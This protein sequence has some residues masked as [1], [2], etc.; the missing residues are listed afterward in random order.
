MNKVIGET[1]GAFTKGQPESTLGNWFA[2]IIYEQSCK[3]YGKPIDFATQN[4]GGLRIPSLPKGELTKGKIYE[5]MPFDNMV[6]ILE[7][8]AATVVQL[9]ERIAAQGGWPTSKQLRFEIKDDK[10]Q[11]IQI[12]GKPFDYD[13]TYLVSLPDY[14]ANGGGRCF[15]LK[16]QKRNE[17]GKLVRDALL[18]YIVECKKNN[19][20]M[21]FRVGWEDKDLLRGQETGEF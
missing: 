3:Y 10:V 16:D 6:V 1:A 4:Y 19:T 20:I 5:L 9:L 11:N 13:K 8:D 21:Y 18:E 15:F 7:L 17:T 12:N 14:I 2:D